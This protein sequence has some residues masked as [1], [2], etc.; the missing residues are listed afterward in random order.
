M[1]DWDALWIN[2]NI[3]TMDPTAGPCVGVVKGGIPRT[4]LS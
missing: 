4:D 3:A 2:G 1:V